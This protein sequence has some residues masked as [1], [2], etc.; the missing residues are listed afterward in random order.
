MN[1]NSKPRS[2]C[3]ALS[4][5]TRS[6]RRG[7]RRRRWVRDPDPVVGRN[8]PISPEFVPPMRILDH[9]GQGRWRWRRTG[10]H[11]VMVVIA[12]DCVCGASLWLVKEG[13]HDLIKHGK[14]G[15]PQGHIGRG[16]CMGEGCAAPPSC[17]LTYTNELRSPLVDSLCAG[18]VRSGVG[19]VARSPL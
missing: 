1:P 6:N 18:P 10:V 7:W 19:R 12:R 11:H 5:G 3:D 2:P 17:A 16:P 14:G 9:G 13:A 15:E 4:W 8:H